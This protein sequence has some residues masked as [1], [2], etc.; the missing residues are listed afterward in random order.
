ME[1]LID[2]LQQLRGRV[3]IDLRG[4]NV[5][6]PQVRGQPREPRVDVLPV[7]VPRQQAMNGKRVPQI[8]NS[9]AGV[10][11]MGNP[12]LAQEPPKGGMDG[13]VTQAAAAAGSRTTARR[14]HQGRCAAVFPRTDPRHRWPCRSG[15]PSGLCGT[16][17]RRHRGFAPRGGSPPGSKRTLRRCGFPCYTKAPEGSGRCGGEASSGA[18]VVRRPPTASAPRWRYRCAAGGRLADGFPCGVRERN[19]AGRSA[20]GT[21]RIAGLRCK[22]LSRVR[23]RSRPRVS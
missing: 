4:L 22:R 5:H 14:A 1:T 18:A 21:R 15:T 8:V 20:R 19:I 12:A 16:F 23:G 6:V 13:R 9:R 11:V 3:E 2:L 10:P 17:P 7:A